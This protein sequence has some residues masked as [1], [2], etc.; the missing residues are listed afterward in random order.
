MWGY[1]KG[2]LTVK[3]VKLVE[4]KNWKLGLLNWLIILG[5]LG[6]IIGVQIVWHKGYQKVD[7][8]SGNVNIKVKGNAYTNVSGTIQNWDEFDAIYPPKEDNAFFL[9][10]SYVA[11]LRQKRDTCTTI[12]K[13]LFCDE[14]TPCV[15]LASKGTGIIANDT[16]INNR[17]Y[18]YAWCPI[19]NDKVPLIHLQGIQNFTVFPKASGFF[20]HFNLTVSNA[21]GPK[22]RDNYNLF[23]ISTIL[24]GSPEGDNINAA[25]VNLDE[26][27]ETGALIVGTL[28]WDCNLDKSPDE[29]DATMQFRR[30]DEPNPKK[31]FSPG[32]NFR[33]TSTYQSL[34][35]GQ[36]VQRRD[37]YK[38][39]GLR[40]VF[41]VAG[42]GGKFDFVTMVTSLGSG[43]ALLSIATVIIDIMLVYIVPRKDV[44]KVH[45]FESLSR[46][47]SELPK[48]NEEGGERQHLLP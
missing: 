29:C 4:I 40:F 30:V 47:T 22:I 3:T 21:K 20:P 17:C 6:Y 46:P 26:V 13:T 43:I 23:N 8:L 18:A 38:A 16:C 5:L 33:Y 9:T 41:L 2:F 28:I 24:N 1:V 37:L 10:T 31:T 27:M 42:T 35:N 14:T 36:Y 48:M 34:E 12:D 25:H 11:T 7:Q 39:Y 19:E 45:K 44:Y 15:P 32:Y